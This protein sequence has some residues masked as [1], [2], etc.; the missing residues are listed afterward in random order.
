MNNYERLQNGMPIVF[1]KDCKYRGSDIEC[2]MRYEEDH[3]DEEEEDG[4]VRIHH[5][6]TLDDSFCDRGEIWEKSH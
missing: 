5:D 1:C 6:S 2:P 3:Y 4:W